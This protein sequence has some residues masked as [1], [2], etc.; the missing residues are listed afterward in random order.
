M[1]P[2]VCL[3]SKFHN[4]WLLFYLNIPDHT[5]EESNL[6]CTA[7]TELWHNIGSKHSCTMSITL[8]RDATPLQ[9]GRTTR[10]P[11]RARTC[12]VMIEKRGSSFFRNFGKFLQYYAVL[13]IRIEYDSQTSPYAHPVSS[14]EAHKFS[15]TLQNGAQC[16]EQYKSC[17]LSLFCGKLLRIKHHCITEVWANPL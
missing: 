10:S 17:L 6:R 8:F 16:L 15:R 3:V 1:E 13:H 14:R 2:Q 12:I 5:T 4:F 9:S 11:R 7:F